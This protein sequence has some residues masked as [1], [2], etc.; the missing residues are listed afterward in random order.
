MW[1]TNLFLRAHFIRYY[2]SPA[3]IVHEGNKQLGQQEDL[4]IKPGRLSSGPDQE[5]LTEGARWQRWG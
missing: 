5:G 3:T 1:R 4:H 2:I